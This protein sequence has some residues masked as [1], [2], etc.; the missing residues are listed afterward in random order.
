MSS[1]VRPLTQSWIDPPGP[2]LLG[3]G[4]V[5]SVREQALYWVDIE[6]L[7][8]H[9]WQW[10]TEQVRTWPVPCMIG[11]LALREQGGL[12]VAL[13]NGIH[14]M[15]L[16]TGDLTF[17][18]DPEGDVPGTRYN[19]GTVDAAGRFWI[20]GMVLDGAP[21][22]AG[23]YRIE[24]DGRWFGMLTGLGCGNGAG[25][26]PDGTVMYYTDSA[27][28][29]IQAFDFD[30]AT[31]DVS[32]PRDFAVDV[33]CDPD[34]LTVD[35]EG[36][37]WGAKWGGGRLVR[38]APDGSIDR[39]VP[40]PVPQPSSIAF[41]GPELRTMFITT[42]RSGMSGAELDLAPLSGQMLVI[43]DVGVTGRADPLTTL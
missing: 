25:F 12:V 2:S 3:E 18:V 16:T 11:A 9:R 23:L 42:A 1:D 6:G 33:D 7:L 22:S 4:P 27:T 19:D 35:A 5:W 41:G 28:K 13:Q 43:D 37:V 34:G 8:V 30:V 32:S 36:F 14:T 31:G 21:A 24:A 17:V 39:V 10:G 20:G 40:V 15:D 26:S 29:T 38:Y